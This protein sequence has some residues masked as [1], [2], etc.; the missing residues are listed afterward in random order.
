MHSFVG[1]GPNVAG[2][3]VSAVLGGD[4]NAACDE[5]SA[6]G[7][8]LGNDVGSMGGAYESFIGGGQDNVIAGF[9]AFVGAGASNA[10]SREYSFV[11]AGYLN[12]VSGRGSF[13]GAGGDTALASSL[14]NGTIILHANT[15]SGTDSFIGSGDLNSVSGNGSFIGAGGSAYASTGPPTVPGNQVIGSDSFI[16]AGDQNTIAAEGAFV[17]SGLLNDVQALGTDGVLAGGRGNVLSGEY[18]S[19]IGGFGNSATGSYAVVAG[20]DGNTAAGILSL[21]AG[22]HAEAAHSGS[23]VWSD[24]NSGSPIV[25]DSA[26]NQFVARASGGVYFYSNETATVGVHLAPGSGTWASL[27]DRDAKADIVPLDEASI[28]TRLASLPLSVWRYKTESGVRHLG[29]MA[30][31]FYAA[32]GVGEDD[33]HITSI[34]EDGVALAAIK[35][36]DAKLDRKDDQIAALRARDGD[37]RLQIVALGVRSVKLQAQNDQLQRRLALLERK[38]DGSERSSRPRAAAVRAR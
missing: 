11:G 19:V 31:D 33:R 35:A 22:Y 30:Q 12:T 27:S 24:Y 32:F 2:G 37:T 13:V 21:V 20:G 7:S 9:E 1:I 28:L 16:G 8:G 4:E 18:G 36:L 17:G 3:A 29:P 34:D 14:Q 26:V 15:V 23:F 10:V 5:Y 6:I 38:I 25:K